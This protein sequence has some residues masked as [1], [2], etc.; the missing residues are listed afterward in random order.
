MKKLIVVLIAAFAVSGCAL[1]AEEVAKSAETVGKGLA[2]YCANM[3]D[4]E[5]PAF[6]AAVEAKFGGTIDLTCP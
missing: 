2:E 5:R 3:P 4:S 6:K 1:F